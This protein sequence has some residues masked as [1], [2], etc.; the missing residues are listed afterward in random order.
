MAYSSDGGITWTA[1][2]VNNTFGTSSNQFDGQVIAY[3]SGKF[4]ICT[5]LASNNG[6]MWTSTNGS[7]WTAASNPPFSGSDPFEI[8]A[9][10][11]NK[12]IGL[13]NARTCTVT[14]TDVSK[15]TVVAGSTS[16]VDTS[17][18]LFGITVEAIAYGNGKFVAVGNDFSNN[19]K[20]AYLSN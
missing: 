6:K 19:G 9:Y 17:S 8:I 10:G 18:G 12:F 20:I 3:G 7:T 11:N 14:S 15:W 1:V 16:K 2:N 4:V 5:S 13:G